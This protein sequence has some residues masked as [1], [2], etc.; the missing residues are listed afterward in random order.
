MNIDIIYIT[1]YDLQTIYYFLRI[2]TE[3]TDNTMVNK[4]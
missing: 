4:L 3:Q 1:D 2:Q